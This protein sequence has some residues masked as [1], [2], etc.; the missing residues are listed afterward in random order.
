LGFN[1]KKKEHQAMDS[2]LKIIS[3][4]IQRQGKDP[5]TVFHL[6]GWLDAQSE[7]QLLT[8]AREAHAAG[9]R[10]LILD[11]AEISMLT[12]TG[13]RAIQKV[14]MIFTP[15]DQNVKIDHMKLCNAL[16]QVY[17]VLGVT[18]FLQTMPMYESLQSAL[19]SYEV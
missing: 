18:G 14:Y 17:H 5:V 16:P 12:S 8:Q 11:L 13:M 1:Y 4:Q 6:R 15:P 3:E 10:Y 2:D 9:A 19:D 7:E